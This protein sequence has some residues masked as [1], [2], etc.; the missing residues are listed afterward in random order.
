MRAAISVLVLTA[1]GGGGAAPASVDGPIAVDAQVAP[2]AQ[3]PPD[4]GPVGV[5]ATGV[6]WP[7]ADAL[8]HQDPTWLGSDAAYSIDLGGGRVAWLFGDSFIATSAA[9]TRSQSHM[10]RNTIAV[11]TGLDPTTATMQ[12]AWGDAAG[13]PASFFPER[14]DRWHWPGGGVR[15]AGGPLIVFLSILRPDPGGLGFASDGWRAVSIANPDDPPAQWQQTWLEPPVQAWDAVVG[16]AVARDGD[17]AIA[18]A[19]DASHHGMLARFPVASL[20]AG[21]LG[22]I[23]WWDGAAWGAG[24]PA[25]VIDDAGPEASLAFDDALGQ[26]IHVASRGFGASTIA[27]RTAPAVT[28][29]WSAP[30]DAFTPPESLGARPFVYAGKAHAELATPDGSLAV[31]YATNSFTFA[32]LF[33]ADGQAHL[34]WPRFVRLALTPRD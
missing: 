27:V 31:T 7:E 3:M 13:T 9:H 5:T 17:F 30:L 28:G 21:S 24:P 4:G 32:D 2:D 20:A 10:A 8:F 19:T 26:W 16:T 1:C 29:P 22:A 12:F 6:S 11:E 34:Y 33:T 23:Q 15:L 18:L 25:I 14:A